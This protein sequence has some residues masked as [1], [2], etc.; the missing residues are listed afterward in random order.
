MM[1]TLYKKNNNDTISWWTIQPGEKEFM[2]PYVPPKPFVPKGYPQPT[3]PES[4]EEKLVP[5]IIKGYYTWW[6]SD[7]NT[8]DA[9]TENSQFTPYTDKPTMSIKEQIEAKTR[10]M[11]AR[12]GYSREITKPAPEMPMLAQKWK[13]FVVLAASDKSDV[14]HFQAPMLQP[15]LD[16]IRCIGTALNMYSRKNLKFTA[17]PHIAACLELL[18]K[19]P[20][21]ENIRLDGELYMHGADLQAIQ[22]MVSSYTTYGNM[23]VNLSYYVFDHI[24]DNVFSQRYEEIKHV[25]EQ[26]ETLWTPRIAEKYKT[27]GCP[28]KLVTTDITER[29]TSSTDFNEMLIQYNKLFREQGYEGVIV[30]NPNASYQCDYRT[31]DLL[32]YK[33]FCDAEFLIV[34][35]LEAKNGSKFKCVTSSGNHF[36]VSPAWTTARKEQVLRYKDNYIGRWLTVT[37]ERISKDGIPLKPIGKTIRQD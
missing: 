16:G 10:E 23:H 13:D 11:I 36:T 7:H 29:T 8:K 4:T 25:V 19:I 3:P 35:V 2:V 22:G 33:E 37:Y 28:I 12:K 27:K 32:K 26:L 15:K 18:L 20:G 6:G 5:K 34:D 31:Y 21:F 30:R 24:S 17:L 1:T 14:K 9:P